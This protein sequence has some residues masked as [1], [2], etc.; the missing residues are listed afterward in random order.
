M[1]LVLTGFEKHLGRFPRVR[2]VEDS[3]QAVKLSRRNWQKEIRLKKPSF[4]AN[5]LVVPAL[6]ATI[7]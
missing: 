6:T 1:F 3:S 7:E 2:H 5:P 4:G